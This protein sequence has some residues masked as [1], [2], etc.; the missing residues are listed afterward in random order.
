MHPNPA[1]RK[2]D[3]TTNITFARDVGFG[4]LAVAT[5][6]APLISHVPFLLSG[7]GALAE[8][9]LVRS[10]PIA[11]ALKSPLPARLAVQGPH[12][13]ISPDWYEIEDQVP[14][15]NYVA[16]HLTGKIEM[17]PQVELRDL[18]DRQ[19]AFYEQKLRPKSS[20]TADKM[21][22]DALG[23]MMRQIVP[24][25]MKVEAIEG[26][27]KLNQ[28]KADEV[29]LRAADQVSS[30]GIG[31]QTTDLAAWMRDPPNQS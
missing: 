7:D 5:E 29:R 16:V 23:K 30:R 24:C 28:N 15:W 26:T 9:H 8:F 27:W 1:F 25:R 6:N 17:R 20:W 22:P 13:Y 19:S 10:N 4:V 31:V 14:T 12:S 11:R 2:P 21:T 18:L 3:D